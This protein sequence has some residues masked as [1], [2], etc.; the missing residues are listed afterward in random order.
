M[1]LDPS[2]ARKKRWNI[3][4]IVVHTAHPLRPA[5]VTNRKHAHQE[6]FKTC[7]TFIMHL[8]AFQIVIIQTYFSLFLKPPFFHYFYVI[9]LPSLVS[10]ALTPLQIKN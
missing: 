1:S 4:A 9:L 6:R 5:A 10:P 7:F 8:N 3:A 2:G